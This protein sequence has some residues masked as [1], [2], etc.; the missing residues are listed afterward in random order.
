MQAART[1]A[2]RPQRFRRCR[3]SAIRSGIRTKSGQPSVVT[4]RMKS[5]NRTL[6][7]GHRSTKATHRFRSWAGGSNWPPVPPAS[8]RESTS[9]RE[10]LRPCASRCC[11]HLLRPRSPWPYVLA[12]AGP[13]HRPQ[14]S[15]PVSCEYACKLAGRPDFARY[16]YLIVLN[17][18][19]NGLTPHFGQNVRWAAYSANLETAADG[20][21]PFATANQYLPAGPHQ[22][23]AI[24]ALNATPSQLQFAPSAGNDNGLSV[25]FSRSILNANAIGVASDWKFNVVVLQGDTLEDYLGTCAS[26]FESPVLAVDNDVPHRRRRLVAKCAA[27][28]P[29]S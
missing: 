8:D 6:G 25:T 10:C 26:C 3:N 13:S 7:E 28:G 17:T 18:S 19:G 24:V 22:P 21:G 4:R 16:Q 27:G 1:S 29:N 5:T 2:V 15:T 11:R 9:L 14:V 12:L 20:D 23:P